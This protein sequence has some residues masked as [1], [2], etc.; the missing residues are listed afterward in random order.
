MAEHSLKEK[1]WRKPTAITR[2]DPEHP[3]DLFPGK[4][5]QLIPEKHIRVIRH[6]LSHKHPFLTKSDHLG[7]LSHFDGTGRLS[8]IS[9]GQKTIRL[10][11]PRQ[12]KGSFSLGPVKYMLECFLKY[13]LAIHGHD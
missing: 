6:R 13:Y 5:A 12:T 7:Q 4:S 2:D 10:I 1:H 8:T 9:T 3:S 11:V